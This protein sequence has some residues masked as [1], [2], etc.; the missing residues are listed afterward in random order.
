MFVQ[1]WFRQCCKFLLCVRPLFCLCCNQGENKWDLLGRP[2]RGR[3]AMTCEMRG[4]CTGWCYENKVFFINSEWIGPEETVTHNFCFLKVCCCKSD[5]SWKI[6]PCTWTKIGTWNKCFWIWTSLFS[7]RQY[8][9]T[10]LIWD[11]IWWV[12]AQ[13]AK[14]K[15]LGALG[16]KHSSP[17]HLPNLPPNARLSTGTSTLPRLPTPAEPSSSFRRTRWNQGE[18]SQLWCEPWM[19]ISRASPSCHHLQISGKKNAQIFSNLF[20]L[21]GGWYQRTTLGGGV[22]WAGF[23]RVSC[24]GW[25]LAGMA[26]A[27]RWTF[28]WKAEVLDGKVE[29]EVNWRLT[30]SVQFLFLRW[31]KCP[32]HFFLPPKMIALSPSLSL[33]LFLSLLLLSLSLIFSHWTSYI[34]IF[35]GCESL[36]FRYIMVSISHPRMLFPFFLG[37][38]SGITVE[39][40]GE[41]VGCG[42]AA[43]LCNF[44]KGGVKNVCWGSIYMYIYMCSFFNL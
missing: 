28:P 15:N 25:F 32:P 38:R 2:Q 30:K 43:E 16:T 23:P 5:T 27:S 9:W 17:H 10:H 22:W 21:R 12:N 20:T 44:D 39:F 40:Q 19:H 4:C 7:W 33:S 24:L 13:Q 37:A 41:L 14:P 11:I 6:Q 42:A 1:T 34:H 8:A 36:W 35:D 31:I 18:N 3:P 26:A 29:M